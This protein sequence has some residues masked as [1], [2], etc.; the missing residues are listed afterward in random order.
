VKKG[1]FG[2]AFIVASE[3]RQ[4][5]TGSFLG[6]ETMRLLEAVER[7]MEEEEAGSCAST[8]DEAVTM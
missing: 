1:R 5:S 3:L 4:L 2:E 7:E 6:S 8:T